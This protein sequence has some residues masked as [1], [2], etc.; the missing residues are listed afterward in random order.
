MLTLVL[1][2]TSC[3]APKKT[4]SESLVTHSQESTLTLDTSTQR[5]AW[6][7]ELTD[8]L[9]EARIEAWLASKFESSLDTERDVEIYDTHQPSDSTTGKPPLL[10]KIRERSH[11]ESRGE[12]T[13]STKATLA[14]SLHSER[15]DSL[16]QNSAG[17]STAAARDD[18]RVQTKDRE[19]KPGN[20]RSVW[21]ILTLSALILVGGILAF[22]RHSNNH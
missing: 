11:G 17:K 9:L 3:A 6:G 19:E 10:A 22:K 12:Q 7:R 18:T 4:V 16:R 15:A 14:D 1:L 2:S 8:R 21:I 20:R 13:G 5:E